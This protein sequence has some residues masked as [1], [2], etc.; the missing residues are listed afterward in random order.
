MTSDPNKNAAWRAFAMLDSDATA[1]FDD[2]ASRDPELS[3]AYREMNCL[4]AAV[5]AATTPPI[6]PRNGQFEKL[7]VRLGLH[8]SKRPNWIGISGWAAA[9]VLTLILVLQKPQPPG[10]FTAANPPPQSG[11]TIKSTPNPTPINA[12]PN[13]IPSP[14]TD[15]PP[16][17]LP[18]TTEPT[19]EPTT[20]VKT[21]TKRLIQE[22]EVLREQLEN[23]HAR[24]RMLFEVIHG[25]A[26]PVIMQMSPPKLT[27]KPTDPPSI[28]A[29]E[30][31]PPEL[32]NLIADALAANSRSMA[33]QQDPPPDFEMAPNPTAP[34]A[35]PIYDAAR[36]NG[37]LVVNNLP[38]PLPDESYN[39]WV[40]TENAASPI[41]VGRL[42]NSETATADSFDFSLGSKAVIP[43]GFILTKDPGNS[44]T[45]PSPSNTV[46]LGPR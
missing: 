7:Q 19:T 26:W 23:A 41:H 1:T 36:D 29:N 39:L 37:T 25:K 40:T 9:A 22:I 4:A 27:P 32:T 11:S 2:A 43:S 42:P 16:Q 20:I 14:A 28:T 38:K 35:I 3:E 18:P 34:S 10:F 6:S 24:D 45:T 30:Q 31:S 15:T 21:E 46:L 12:S 5:A 17:P 8:P 13:P 44:I 33:L